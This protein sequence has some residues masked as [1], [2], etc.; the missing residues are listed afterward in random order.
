[1][2]RKI[3]KI[4]VFA[5][6]FPINLFA[7]IENVIVETYYIS[8]AN[9]ATD[10]TGGLL[11]IGS[12]TYRIFIDLVP[13]SKLKKIYG[14][15]NHPLIFSSTTPFFNNKA[16]GQSFA[17]DFSK[18]RLQENTVALDS[19]LTLGQATRIAAKTYFGVIKSNDVN[20]SF[21][22]GV[23]NDGG[24]AG[25]PI[26]LL[27]NADVNAGTPITSVDGLDTMSD[28]PSSWADYGFVDNIS[29]LDSTI[30]G[31]TKRGIDFISYNAGLQNSGVRGID[32]GSNQ[33]LVAQLTTTGEI[34][35]ELNL[36]VEESFGGTTRIIKYVANSNTLLS[37]ERLCPFLK[38]PAMC[39]CTDPHY[40]EFNPAYSCNNSDSCKNIIVFGCTDILACNFNPDANYNIPELC[41]YPGLCND[42]DLSIVCPQLSAQKVLSENF[43]LHPNP[44]NEKIIVSGNIPM[45]GEIYIVVFDQFGKTVLEERKIIDA[46]NIYQQLDVSRFKSGIYF[47]K[48]YSG[49]IFQ[50]SKFCI[51]K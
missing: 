35:F 45:A 20:G 16:D 3:F 31:S 28:I 7:Q 9:D 21:I 17:K 44:A 13:G 49:E 33:V 24:S 19:W 34:S 43:V 1:M 5:Y 41:C 11:P 18:T 10:T 51:Y 12:K 50:S 32:P 47:M 14:D 22:G 46:G 40:V 2:L 36:E 37:D 8:D 48:I 26:G 38:Y 29:G 27:T 42:R 15:A 4:I 25:I 23:N 6:I 30:F 39:G